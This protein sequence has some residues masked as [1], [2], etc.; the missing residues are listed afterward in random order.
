MYENVGA[1]SCIIMCHACFVEGRVT[2]SCSVWLCRIHA[3]I[4]IQPE[5]ML[6][7]FINK[8]TLVLTLLLGRRCD[9]SKDVHGIEM[10]NYVALWLVRCMLP[11]LAM[12]HP[13]NPALRVAVLSLRTQI[14]SK[15]TAAQLYIALC[16][17]WSPAPGCV[18]ATTTGR[19]AHVHGLCCMYL[20]LA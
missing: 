15:S 5:R 4:E 13:C 12:P 2:L 16:H 3:G 10:L 9:S 6:I 18:H 20:A 19:C 7:Q 17:N 8:Q 14:A 1:T 11:L